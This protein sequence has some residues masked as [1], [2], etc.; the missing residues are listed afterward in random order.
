MNLAGVCLCNDHLIWRGNASKTWQADELVGVNQVD[1]FM[2]VLSAAV[3]RKCHSAVIIFKPSQ[4]RNQ[5]S[6][7]VRSL[8]YFL[9][10][11]LPQQQ[12]LQ[13]SAMVSKWTSP[14]RT[15]WYWLKLNWIN[16]TSRE[17]VCSQQCKKQL[18]QQ[19]RPST[20]KHLIAT[21]DVLCLSDKCQSEQFKAITTIVDCCDFA[22][23][24]CRLK[25]PDLADQEQSVCSTV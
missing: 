22:E 25:Q 16:D 17:L 10:T 4:Y 5:G 1:C 2:C 9:K 3:P 18:T 24:V 21:R 13:I 14:E 11:R 6:A 12:K 20:L 19:Y 8:F 23:E 7:R 15:T